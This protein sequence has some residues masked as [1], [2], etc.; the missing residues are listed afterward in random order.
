[1]YVCVYVCGLLDKLVDHRVE[2]VKMEMTPQEG[3]DFYVRMNHRITDLMK[4]FTKQ[5]HTHIHTHHTH[6]HAHTVTTR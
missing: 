4:E 2:S 3:V 5:V 6:T 1:M